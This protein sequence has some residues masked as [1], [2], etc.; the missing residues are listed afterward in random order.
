MSHYPIPKVLT[1]AYIEGLKKSIESI[2]NRPQKYKVKQSVG[3]RLKNSVILDY[4]NMFYSNTYIPMDIE[5]V[6]EA[7]EVFE[8]VDNLIPNRMY[9]QGLFECVPMRSEHEQFIFQMEQ[10][11]EWMEDYESDSVNIKK[12][13]LQ[14]PRP[15]K[16]TQEQYEKL[17]EFQD[18]IMREAECCFAM[19]LVIS[20]F[21]L[22]FFSSMLSW[23]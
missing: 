21:G 1:H 22:F 23:F 2:R 17:C 6:T 20:F 12:R 3:E 19:E 5:T 13:K 4:F 9:T 15:M 8:R 18:Q 14:K 11:L 7:A 10:E 16:L